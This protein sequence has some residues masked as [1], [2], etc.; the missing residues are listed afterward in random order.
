MP[1]TF[2]IHPSILLVTS[3]EW[4]LFTSCLIDCHVISV[5]HD[6]F[7]TVCDL[8]LFMHLMIESSHSTASTSIDIFPFISSLSTPE[9]V[10]LHLFFS[11]PQIRSACAIRFHP[12]SFRSFILDPFLAFCW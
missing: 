11:P 2:L 7:R 6:C 3:T 1:T 4:L 12:Q 10:L 8:A 9:H 5:L